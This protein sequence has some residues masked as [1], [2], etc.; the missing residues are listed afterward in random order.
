MKWLNIN[1]WINDSNAMYMQN[2][3]NE[4]EKREKNFRYRH[5]TQKS[6]PIDFLGCKR[7]GIIT[8]K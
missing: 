5:S 4:K 2:I 1:W 3:K 8:E 6:I 7:K